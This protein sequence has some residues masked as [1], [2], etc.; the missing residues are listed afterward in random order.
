MLKRSPRAL[1]RSTA[2]GSFSTATDSP[3]SADSS[4]RSS[5]SR[6]RRRSAGTLSP[7]CSSTRSPGTMSVAGTQRV[8]AAHDGRL[9][10]H[11]GG[12]RLDRGDR[13]G[14]LEVADERVER[15]TAK[16]T[17][18][19]TQSLRTRVTT[20]AP[21]RMMISGSLNW[22]RRRSRALGPER[23][24]IALAPNC[25]C[26]CWTAKRSSPCSASVSS[27]S[28]TSSAGSACQCWSASAWI[29]TTPVSVSLGLPRACAGASH[30]VARRASVRPALA[31]FHA[32]ILH[33]ARA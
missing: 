19:S 10:G 32:R 9:G 24:V 21:I 6:T 5:R 30:D 2:A 12:E 7:A 22:A 33:R 25:A 4:T 18:A 27:R 28:T 14:L 13:L 1:S 15:T 11:R 26:R 23:C 31:R 17:M 3:V 8:P 16:I 29:V 20:P